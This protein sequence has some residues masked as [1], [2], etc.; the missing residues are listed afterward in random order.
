MLIFMKSTVSDNEVTYMYICHT[1]VLFSLINIGIS[2]TITLP[3][4]ANHLNWCGRFNACMFLTY[5]QFSADEKLNKVL[6]ETGQAIYF[7]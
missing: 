1:T 5:L 3:R 4:Q 6:Q 2:M 7:N